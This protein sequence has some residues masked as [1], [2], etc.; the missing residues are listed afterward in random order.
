MPRPWSLER[1]GQCGLHPGHCHRRDSARSGARWQQIE[2]GQGHRGTEVVGRLGRAAP[3]PWEAANP[4]RVCPA[5]TVPCPG[6]ASPCGQA[7]VGS[8]HGPPGR[9]HRGLQRPRGQQQLCLGL[10][11]GVSL[12]ESVK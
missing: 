12:M 1:Y 3:E 10:S 4:G 7:G 2:G 11:W 9:G 8:G 5:V 6:T